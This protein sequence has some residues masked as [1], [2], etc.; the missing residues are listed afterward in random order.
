M[1]IELLT[2]RYPGMR[3]WLTQRLSAV[4]MALYTLLFVL[5]VAIQQP[6]NYQEWHA[7][8]SPW[9]W[10]LVTILFWI[11]LT[12]HAWLGVRDVLKDYVFNLTLRS[13]L[14]LLVELALIV[15]LIW[16]VM[17]LMNLNTGTL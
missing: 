17:I 13:Y 5:L 7:F 15:D 1:L 11:C 4:V 6:T 10:R 9:W 12:M 14:Q 16:L 8:F 2:D 3:Q